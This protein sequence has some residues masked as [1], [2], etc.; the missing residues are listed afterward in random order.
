[1]AFVLSKEA[2]KEIMKNADDAFELIQEIAG[3][4]P[5]MI[6]SDLKIGLAFR[7]GFLI[8]AQ[9][10]LTLSNYI[11]IKE[12]LGIPKNF[13]ESLMMLKSNKILS[14]E[15]GEIAGFI[16]DTR[17]LILHESAEI[18]TKD[19]KSIS[20]KIEKI[21]EMYDRIRQKVEQYLTGQ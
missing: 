21:K 16:V 1:M 12:N 5:E 20:E 18:S 19:I 4:A 11:V 8:A 7:Y 15:D 14:K 3:L 17:N 10:I 6:I 13:L 2:I 9:A